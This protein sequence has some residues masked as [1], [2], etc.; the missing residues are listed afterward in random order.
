MS[1]VFVWVLVTGYASNIYRW[2]LSNQQT[3]S[4]VIANKSD[5][6]SAKLRMRSEFATQAK[7]DRHV[8]ANE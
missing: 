5:F 7:D 2:T 6:F 1:V 4:I 3:C 8:E